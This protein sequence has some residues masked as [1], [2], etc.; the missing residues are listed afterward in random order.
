MKMT[1]RM[2]RLHKRN[3]VDRTVTGAPG[4]AVAR[5]CYKKDDC[6]MHLIHECPKNFWDSL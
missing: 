6:A 5:K 1:T 3:V 2:I 4:Y